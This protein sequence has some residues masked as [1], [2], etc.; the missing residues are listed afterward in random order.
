MN[1][2]TSMN[3]RQDFRRAGLIVILATVL[4][5][6]LNFLRVRPVPLLASDGPG[7]WPERALR[8]SIAEIKRMTVNRQPMLL[9]DI[10][11]ND[12]YNE[13]HIAMAINAPAIPIEAFLKYY[14]DIAPFISAMPVTVLICESDDCVTGDRIAQILKEFKHDNVRVLA[15]GWNAAKDSELEMAGET[16]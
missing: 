8:I 9:L 7:A 13:R 11:R 2:K 15:G 4:A 5:L 6:S 3:W 1:L 14:P 12:A 10:R 16:R